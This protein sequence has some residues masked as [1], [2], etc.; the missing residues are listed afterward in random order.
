[1]SVSDR[2]DPDYGWDGRYVSSVRVRE[3]APLDEVAA[4]LRAVEAMCEP[5]DTKLLAAELTRLRSLTARRA[6]TGVDMEVTIGAWIEELQAYSADAAVQALREWPGANKWWPTWAEIREACERYGGE[7]LMLLAALR[8]G[9]RRAGG[10]GMRAL[11]DVL[12]GVPGPGERAAQ[13]QEG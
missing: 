4:A 13:G 11:A 3:D 2:I 12:T 9:P 5:A 10:P 6:E 8:R 7:R 1:M